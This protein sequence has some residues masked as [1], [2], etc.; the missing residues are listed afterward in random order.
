MLFVASS[1]LYTNT[2]SRPTPKTIYMSIL[3]QIMGEYWMRKVIFCF[4]LAIG[5]LSTITTGNAST[6]AFIY[7]TDSSTANDY[8]SLFES[9]GFTTDL[10]LTGN[11]ATTDFLKYDLIIIGSDISTPSGSDISKI[12]DSAKPIIGLGEGGYSFFGGL[13]LKTGYPNGWHGSENRIYTVDKTYTVFNKPNSI[14]IP[15]NYILQ[16]YSSTGHV[17]IH[18]PSVPSNVIVLG[19]ESTDTTHY[20]FTLEDSKYLLWGF[21]ASPTSMTQIG[22]DLFINSISYLVPRTPNGRIEVQ[23][24]NENATFILSGPATYSGSGSS[25]NQSN[26]SPGTYTITYGSVRGYQTPPSETKTL[27]AGGTIYFF[28]NYLS[29]KRAGD[30]VDFGDGYVLLIKGV[31]PEEGQVYI[32]L[33]LDNNTISEKVLKKKESYE[34]KKYNQEPFYFEVIDIY[35]DATD[36]YVTYRTW[37]FTIGYA[38]FNLNLNVASSPPGANIMLDNV[39]VGVTPKKITIIDLEKH[40]LRLVLVG[41][42]DEE[43]TFKFDDEM[44]KNKDIFITLNKIQP[45]LKGDV[46]GDGSITGIDA[47]WIDQYVVGKR[48]GL[49]TNVADVNGDGTITGIDSVWIDQY[50]VGKRIW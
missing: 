12:S 16:L 40:L 5:L 34:I 8:K 26:I 36:D 27:S 35:H 18:L 46:N 25:W 20:P 15:T 42:K 22:K 31:N 29:K 6:I 9:A 38:H 1:G 49:N 14:T 44:N 10:I 47:V 50:V 11:I 28:G 39:Y 19:R 7:S 48:T 21:T 32:E 30:N 45:T 13:G 33:K 43:T 2:Q 4:L 3:I 24:F 37:A 41:Y 17:G 23:T